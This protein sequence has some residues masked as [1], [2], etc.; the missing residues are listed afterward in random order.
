M[1]SLLADRR[2]EGRRIRSVR[3]MC[4]VA[5]LLVLVQAGLG[6]AVNL[7]VTI[8]RAHPGGHGPGGYLSR[9]YHSVRWALASSPATLASH[10]G[11][12]L[13]LIVVALV[14][15]VR[16]VAIRA[17]WAAVLVVLA[18]LLVVGA[19]FNGASFLDFNH[20]VSSL[21]MALLAFGAVAAYVLA[22]TILGDPGRRY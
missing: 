1:R 16:A 21:I 18:A 19:A 7:Y 14:L 15:A 10:A 20:H 2:A 8:P 22:A 5:A 11:F 9:S 6:M 13:V 4:V 12:G 3:R 17:G